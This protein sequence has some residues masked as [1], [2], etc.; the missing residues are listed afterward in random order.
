MN[1]SGNGISIDLDLPP[2]AVFAVGFPFDIYA[3]PSPDGIL[4]DFDFSFFDDT[5]ADVTTDFRLDGR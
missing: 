1:V 4:K 3:D 2:G 5:G